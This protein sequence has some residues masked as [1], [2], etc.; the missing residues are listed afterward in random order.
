MFYYIGV[1]YPMDS[2]ILDDYLHIVHLMGQLSYMSYEYKA[3]GHDLQHMYDNC[4]YCISFYSVTY[5]VFNVPLSSLVSNFSVLEV[6]VHKSYFRK[7][8]ILIKN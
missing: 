3:Y 6:F 8:F 7:E 4:L 5:A 1:L 2:P